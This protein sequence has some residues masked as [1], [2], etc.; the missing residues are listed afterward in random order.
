MLTESELLRLA[1]LNLMEFWRDSSKWIPQSEVYESGDT[2][3]INSGHDFPACSFAFNLS[4]AGDVN[5]DAFLGRVKAFFHGKKKAFSLVLRD[6]CDRETIQYCKDKNIFQVSESPGM[7]LDK[8][9]KPGVVPE[10]AELRLVENETGLN[11]FKKVVAEAYMDL[12]FPAEVSEAYFSHAERVLSPQFILAV[13]YLNGEPASC[14][15]AMLSHGIAGIYWVGTM[16][17]ARGR[18]LAEYCVREVGNS[19]FQL[20]ARKIVLQASRFGQPIYQRMGYREFTKYPWFI[21]SSRH[22][23]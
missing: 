22:S 9:L 7:T 5:P 19:A 14:A 20:G 23:G 11:D 13:M 18:G 6:H 2:V 3:F 15:L 8:P 1:D 21:C 16:K 17:Y 12:A 10:G 4:L